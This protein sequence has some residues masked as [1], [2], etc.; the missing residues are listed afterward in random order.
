M[1]LIKVLIGQRQTGSLGRDTRL[2]KLWEQEEQSRN[3]TEKPENAEDNYDALRKHTESHVQ[4][5]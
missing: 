3:A 4:T 1:S 5:G 2:R